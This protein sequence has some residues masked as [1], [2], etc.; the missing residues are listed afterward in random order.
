MITCRNYDGPDDYRRIDRFLIRHYRP[1][2][3]DG[4]W[5]EPAWEYMHAHPYLDESCLRRIGIWEETEE[6]VGVAHYESRL[7]EAFFQFHPGYRHLQ[8]EMLDYAQENL[9]GRTR[10]DGR[11]YLCAFVNDCDRRFISLVKGQGYGKDAEKARPMASMVIPDRFPTILLPEGFR[12][13]SLAEDCDWAKV[14]RVLWRGFDHEGEP[15]AD[16]EELESRREMF[17]TPNARRELKVAVVAPDGEFVAFC[18][19]FYQS[20]GQYAYVEPV[21]TDPSYRRMGLARAAVLEG[22]RR[23]SALGAKVAFVGSDQEFYL[24]MGFRVVYNSECWVRFFE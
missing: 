6:I 19:M 14:N 5:V 15:P 8:P 11:R 16:D 23:C 7:G 18:G 17:D 21:A 20:A 10:K 4:N 22:I 2:N 24:S 9:T 3:L 13:T 1:G 12:L